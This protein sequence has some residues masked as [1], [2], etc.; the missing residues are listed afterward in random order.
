MSK[1]FC[2]LLTALLL[3]LSVILGFFLNENSN[4]V[5]NANV[6]S[7]NDG[8]STSKQDDCEQGFIP[9]CDWLKS[10]RD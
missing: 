2:I 1:K 9:A 5:S 3:A 6:S 4:A 8:F 7:F 10:N